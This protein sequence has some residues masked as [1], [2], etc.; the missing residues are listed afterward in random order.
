LVQKPPAAQNTAAV[1]L[2][3]HVVLPVAGTHV[4]PLQRKPLR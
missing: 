1:E 3:E 4:V 2:A